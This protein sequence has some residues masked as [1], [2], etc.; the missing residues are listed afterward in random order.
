MNERL[1]RLAERFGTPAYVY[2]LAAV[3]DA[4][5]DLRD[6]LPAGTALHYSLKANPH[7]RLVTELA[8]AGCHAEVASIGEVDAALA[9]GL[10]P[11][12]VQLAGPGQVE[13]GFGDGH[14]LA[15]GES[16]HCDHGQPGNRRP[17]IGRE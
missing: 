11:G 6:A 4:H 13:V 9:A 8:M 7:P 12:L 3:R 2:D 16:E 5:R 10:R 15:L 14:P 1:L 17:E